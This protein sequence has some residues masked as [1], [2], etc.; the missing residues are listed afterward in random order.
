MSNQ[1]FAFLL[2]LECIILAVLMIPYYLIRRRSGVAWAN[3]PVYG[4]WAYFLYLLGGGV[5]DR[6]AAV[7]RI[8]LTAFGLLFFQGVLIV[9]IVYMI[10]VKLYGPQASNSSE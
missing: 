5:S 6:M 8:Y 10:L 2:V 7:S 4:L 3:L 1:L 9:V